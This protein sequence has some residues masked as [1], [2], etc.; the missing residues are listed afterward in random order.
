MRSLKSRALSLALGALSVGTI[1]AVGALSPTAAGATTLHRSASVGAVYSETNAI[2]GNRIQVFERRADGS[3]VAGASYA[4]GGTGTGAHGFSQGAVELS[5]DGHTLVAV[6]AGSN[7][8]SQFAV[9]GDGSL[10]LVST[11]S[12]GG[13]QP[14]SVA[15]R[16][17]LVEV[18]NLGGT[19]NVAGFV[20]TPLG[21]VRLRGGTQPLSAGA[22]GAEDVGISPDGSHVVVTEKTS[23]TIDTFQVRSFGRLAP[24]VTSP[25][26]GPGAFAS[27]F[28]P[29]GQLL[30]ADAGGAGTSALSGYRVHSDGTADPTGSAIGNGQS[31]AC[32]IT[33]G[34]DG[35]VFVANAGSAS[36]STYHVRRSGAVDLVGNFDAGVGSKP[37]DLA[38]A[39]HGHYLYELDG[40]NN[41]IS[42]F[43]VNADGSLSAIGSVAIP[44]SAAGLAAS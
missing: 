37:L 39:G 28:T 35:N 2:D 19:A 1:G 23:N 31:A 33:I 5:T 22:A 24:V 44:A 41:T 7:Q 11:V 16:G 30:V 26:N 4:T 27:V 34:A 18:L 25:S 17:S 15:V 6:N 40:N 13:V 3:L 42:T 43:A 20:A 10:H 9:R 29:N 12:S 14:I 8:V 36:I 38:T 21:L 32:W